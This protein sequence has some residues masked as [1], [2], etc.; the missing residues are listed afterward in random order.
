MRRRRFLKT[1]GTVGAAVGAGAFGILKFPRGVHA[2]GWGAW[3]EDKLDALLPEAARA[4]SVLELHVNGGMSTFDTFYTIPSWGQASSTFVHV[5]G[6]GS[7]GI[8][9]L[10]P[11]ARRDDRFAMCAPA[12]V[13]SQGLWVPF[14]AADGAGN[15]IYLGPWIYPFR[16]RPDVLERM[17]IVVQ[18]HDQAAHEGANPVSFTGDRLGTPRMS[19]IGAAIQRYFTENPG[20]PGGSGLRAAP[21]AYILYP[22]GYNPFNAV[23]ATTVG[24]HPGSSRPLALSVDPGSQLYQLLSRPGLDDPEAFDAAI[25]YYRA[26]YENRLIGAGRATPA[27]SPEWSNYQFADFA[28]RHAPELQDVLPPSL[29][30]NIGAPQVCGQGF[31]QPDMPRMQARMAASLLTRATNAA[32]Y[33]MWIDAGLSPSST[34]G[35]DVHNRSI[36]LD[37]I[38]LPHTFEALLEIIRDP[39]N[40]RPG[41]DQRIDLDRTM[42]VINT[43]FGRTPYRQGDTGTNH[44]PSGYVNIFIGGPVN[45]A[46]GNG[47]SVY[48][49]MQESDGV[50][51]QYVRPAENRMMVLQAMGIYPFSSQTFAVGDVP[52]PDVDDELQAAR[53]IRDV[54]LGYQA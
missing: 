20:L 14:G 24:F 54:Y 23:A 39:N 8:D 45:P 47:R 15:E 53:R 13:Q 7:P 21:Y 41:D 50:A 38:N 42:V 11:Q 34:G 30:T 44:W 25:A 22:A 27:R 36:E 49:F 28:R 43:E 9:A 4:Q 18:R 35:H 5:F 33:V 26:A 1:V 46:N 40:P 10:P 16:S 31:P 17:R 32:R 29:F 52:H 48:G 6:P 12:N 19:G 3:P 37:G 2:A 51:V